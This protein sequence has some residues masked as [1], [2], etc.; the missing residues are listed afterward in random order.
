VVQ[1]SEYIVF[2][3]KILRQV[4]TFLVKGSDS[5]SKLHGA[6]EFDVLVYFGGFRTSQPA[7]CPHIIMINLCGTARWEP[8]LNR[9]T[10]FYMVLN[11]VSFNEYYRTGIP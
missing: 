9:S 10:V 1:P 6:N 5:K 3:F 4:S 7:K 8:M 2:E 11:A